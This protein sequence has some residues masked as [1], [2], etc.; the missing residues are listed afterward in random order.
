M[1]EF[2]C[3]CER[4]G[5]RAPIEK[6]EISEGAIK[7]IPNLLGDYKRIYMVA[8]KN[9]YQA[10]GKA[11]EEILVANG[12]LHKTFVFDQTPVLPNTDSIGKVILNFQKLDAK[13]NIFEYNPMPDLI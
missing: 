2:S 1:I 8:D 6:F 13:P 10:A 11:V 4:K 9:T 5:H 3:G 12:M 7:Q